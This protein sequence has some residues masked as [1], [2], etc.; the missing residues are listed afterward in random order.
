[1]IFT[2][3]SVYQPANVINKTKIHFMTSSKLLR[4]SKP[5]FDL[6]RGIYKKGIQA[7]Q[8]DLSI[9]HPY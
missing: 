4:V 8:G 7:Q 9:I 6:Q 1:M 3:Q 2:L 5:E